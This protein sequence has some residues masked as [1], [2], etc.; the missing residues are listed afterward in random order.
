MKKKITSHARENSDLQLVKAN[1]RNFITG[2]VAGGVAGLL[3]LPDKSLA[4]QEPAQPNACAILPSASD[5][6]DKQLYLLLKLQFGVYK[7][8]MEDF[9]K[10][11]MDCSSLLVGLRSDVQALIKALGKEPD[12]P[13]K[14]HATRMRELVHLGQSQVKSIERSQT[15]AQSDAAALAA[16]L[17]LVN[18]TAEQMMEDLLPKGPAPLSPQVLE[19]LNRILNAI[20]RSGPLQEKLSKTQTQAQKAT[21]E[22]N[23]VMQ[24]LMKNIEQA[25]DHALLAEAPTLTDN[26]RQNA[27]KDALEQLDEALK[28]LSELKKPK[29]SSTDQSENSRTHSPE[30][31]E[32]LDVA[33]LLLEGIMVW[34]AV[35]GG[36][37]KPPKKEDGSGLDR[38][39]EGRFVRVNHSGQ[40]PQLS[41]PSINKQIVSDKLWRCCCRGNEPF[42]NAVVTK[43][44][45]PIAYNV[46]CARGGVL[47]AVVCL[48]I[49][50][51]PYTLGEIHADIRNA[52]TQHNM[53][54]ELPEG[55]KKQNC[56][57]D[58]YIELANYVKGVYG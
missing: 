38:M 30:N 9:Y 40:A 22:F 41:A 57:S 55:C 28:K 26:E 32:T 12:P 51:S 46:W 45:Q 6:L 37:I 52:F 19:I 27:R 17:L 11:S 35:E 2:A 33:E 4:A 20:R 49:P 7:E 31:S 5:S 58:I 47:S 25:R 24:P 42:V 10:V 13:G 15:L 56:N 43:V 23:D 18:Q 1:R 16:T 29:Q 53:K 36:N 14:A 8:L 3:A 44:L 39:A 34:I 54:C 48:R 21:N 50:R